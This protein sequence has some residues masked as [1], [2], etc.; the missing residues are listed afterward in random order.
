MGS[1][2]LREF[3]KI[4]FSISR[5]FLTFQR[6]QKDKIEGGFLSFDLGWRSEVSVSPVVG[7]SKPSSSVVKSSSVG[8]E[9]KTR[10]KTMVFFP[11]L[12]SYTHLFIFSLKIP[13]YYH[14]S[15][16]I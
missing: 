10:A 16:T 13:T 4:A 8:D 12:N 6:K 11:S 1:A 7:S 5:L 14:F 2:I 9:R 15:N 3:V